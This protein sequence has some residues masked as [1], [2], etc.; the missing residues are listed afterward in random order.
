M[1]IG[2]HTELIL[3]YVTSLSPH[4][5]LILGLVWLRQHDPDISWSQNTVTFSSPY[6]LR[7]CLSSRKPNMAYGLPTPPPTP[8]SSQ[9]D[10]SPA[11]GEPAARP[12]TSRS[13]GPPA[14][15]K[16]LDT[17]G[18]EGGHEALDIKLIGAAPFAH[19]AKQKDV[20]VTKI[21]LRALSLYSQ[22]R[23]ED[24]RQLDALT[25][26]DFKAVLSTPIEDSF[27]KRFPPTFQAFIEDHQEKFFLNRVTQE[28]IDIFLK[29]KPK[30]SP[31]EIK[32]KLPIEYHEFIDVFSPKE[33]DALPPHRP[34]DH[35]IDLK[36]GTQ[37]PYF[38]NRPMSPRELEAIKKYLDEHLQK[39]FIRASTSPAAA[40]IL[41]AQKPGGGVRVCVDYRGLNALTAKN[42]YPIPLIRETL[43]ALH[44]AK[45]Y[46]KLDII[47]AFNK[48]RIAEGEEWKTAFLTR[49]GLYEYLV[50][51]F[52]LQNAPG[53]F[54]HFINSVLHEF[55]DKFAS[56]YLDDILIYSKTKKAH[57]EHVKKVLLALQKAGLQIDINKCEFNVQETKYL[58]LIISSKGIK[59][60]PKKVAA[61]RDW[62]TPKT[63]KDLQSFL[64][65]ANF[66]RRFIRAFSTIAR[67]LTSLLKST[68]PWDF[69]KECQDAFSNLK[70]A[71]TTA[72]V[73]AHFDPKKKTVVETDA[74]NW[75]SG[76]VLSQYD[77]S[78]ILRPVAYFS[79]KHS[80]QE[81]NYE[82]Y[83]KELLAIIKAFEEWR[84]ELEGTEEEF[85]VITDHKNLQHFMTT[86]LLNQRQA[87]WSEFLSRFNFRIV[88]RPGKQGAK[89]DALSRKAEDRPAS[90]K[91]LFD[92]RIS[93]RFQQVLKDRNISAGMT[94]DKASEPIPLTPLLLYALDVATP[95]DTLISAS[96]DNNHQAQA[97]LA[98]LKDPEQRHWPK[99]LKKELRFPMSECKIIE[100]KI[101]FR[102]KLFIP[103]EEELKLQIITRTHSSAPAGH[104][105]RS[106]TID[107]LRRTYF[108]PGLSKDA[109]RFV[110]NCHQC[111]RSKTSR[112]A[113]QGFLKPLEIPFR[114]WR[115]ISIDYVTPLPECRRYGTTFKHIL[116]IIDRLT[117]MRHFIP[118][119]SLEADELAHCFISSV[120]SL[121]G[122]PE[123]IVSDRGSQFIS[124]FWR[125][126]SKRLGTTL[127]PSSAFHPETNG[128]T[129]NSH[130][131]MEQYLRTFVNFLQDDWV[132]WLPL[133]EFA[134][135]SHVHETT[136]VSPFFANYGFNPRL[137]V[138]PPHPHPPNLSR[139]QKEEF[140]NANS[141]ADRFAKIQEFL[142]QQIANAQ[143]RQELQANKSRAPAP[144]YKEGDEVWL[145]TK[146]LK[147][148]R[149]SRKL[150]DKYKG[151]FKVIRAGTHTVTLDIPREWKIDNTVNNSRVRLAAKD[152]FPG[153]EQVNEAERKDSDDAILVRDEDTG[154][155]H[156]AW[157]FKKILDSRINKRTKKLEYKIQWTNYKPSWQPGIDLKGCD[158][159]LEDFHKANPSRPGPPTWFKGRT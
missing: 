150:D 48:L 5:P 95:I 58:G 73:L 135:N 55:L 97:M 57:Q 23:E 8:A 74:S 76:G 158:S 134:C 14:N 54:Q 16:N 96:Y 129:E 156:L 42:R 38:R 115:D 139:A 20:Q 90:T 30:P 70:N 39:G 49:Y 41:L 105:G 52:G 60:D 148:D 28:D 112:S 46:T 85:E 22:P 6:C 110:R 91:D 86:K 69:N 40:P 94:P 141:L 43:D 72:H 138:E 53:T 63:L 44:N 124:T 121:H 122:A 62:E 83:D 12:T 98:A 109:S 61:I 120:Y 147:T 84:P 88:Y 37:P 82:I 106:K 159:D 67:P 10:L 99:Q 81:C 101:F 113:T 80:P 36:P 92:D 107:L 103:D 68:K 29:G 24:F 35:K 34:F 157:E 25:E 45:Y 19:L 143:D 4:I 136:K 17:P 127:K 87:R 152:P 66:Y 65:F 100:G 116:V 11:V 15:S 21:S 7:H 125:A 146:N 75:A 26:A 13:Q 117:K 128:Q 149:P 144:R 31:E 114:P 79:A 3:A 145:D 56:A 151:P 137:G 77:D 131:S 118:C 93:H 111:T 27:K 51:P 154:E 78:G 142:R 32:K 47:A 123:F 140:F 89:P 119:I 18:K 102:D 132:D 2:E 9:M 155:E 108:W 130:L 126:L 50:M 104:P 64:G 1:T 71:F 33:A 133:A 153:Q 59:M